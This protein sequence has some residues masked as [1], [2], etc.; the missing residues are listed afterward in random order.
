MGD[1]PT[2]YIAGNCV[3]DAF[4]EVFDWL[5]YYTE[6]YLS[7]QN[8]WNNFEL[9]LNYQNESNSIRL[10]RRRFM[11]QVEFEAEKVIWLFLLLNI[12]LKYKTA[13]AL[14]LNKKYI[15]F[16]VWQQTY[17]EDVKWYLTYFKTLL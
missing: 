4:I 14:W 12:F 3:R 9:V 13:K 15:T 6:L 17:A 8:L 2:F 1:H 11:V 16:W 5:S 7:E 10:A